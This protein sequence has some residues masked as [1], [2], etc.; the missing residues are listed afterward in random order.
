MFGRLFYKNKMTF[1]FDIFSTNLKATFDTMEEH[2]K[3]RSKRENVSN[4]I[5]KILTTNKRL[6]S[7]ITFCRF[8]NNEN[9]LATTNYLYTEIISIYPAHQP[10]QKHYHNRNSRNVSHV[11]KD[12]FG[13]TKLYNDVEISDMTSFLSIEE[14]RK[15][16]IVLVLLKDP[17][18]SQK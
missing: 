5:E 8:N 3:G 10:S 6:E 11:N 17:G 16:E 18:L 13:K 12:K 7:A 9:R 1:N 15:T 4:L 2:G 14:W